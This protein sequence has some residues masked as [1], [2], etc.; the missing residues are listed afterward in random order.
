[1][2]GVRTTASAPDGALAVVAEVCALP[3]NSRYVEGTESLMEA[4]G[5]A[6][7]VGV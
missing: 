2:R 3:G 1:M 5:V 4:A 7:A 6:A